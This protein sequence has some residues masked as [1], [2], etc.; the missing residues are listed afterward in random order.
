V[1][2]T[3]GGPGD[4]TREAV[5]AVAWGGRRLVEALARDELPAC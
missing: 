1:T 3:L 5:E 2:V 4:L